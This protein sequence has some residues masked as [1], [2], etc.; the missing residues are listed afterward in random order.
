MNP[1]PVETTQIRDFRSFR[2]KD[3]SVLPGLSD[4]QTRAYSDFLQLEVS[5]SRRKKQGLEALF[6]DA[7]PIESHTK[8]YALEFHGYSLGRPRYHPVE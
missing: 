3:D 4:L 6:D 8:E 7:F 2:F 5:A 1:T